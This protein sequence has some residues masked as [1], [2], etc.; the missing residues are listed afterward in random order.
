MITF[1]ALW[2]PHSSHLNEISWINPSITDNSGLRKALFS[3]NRANVLL[4]CFLSHQKAL[5]NVLHHTCVYLRFPASTIAVG[6][7]RKTA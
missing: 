4:W 3:F 7:D 2:A 6:K 5:M 1:V